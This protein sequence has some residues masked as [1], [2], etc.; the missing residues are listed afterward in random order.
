MQV[1][2]DLP[3]S[4]AAQVSTESHHLGQLLARALRPKPPE[5]SALRREVLSFLAAGPR[6][7]EIIGFR[8][9]E[10]AAA[11]MRD[12]LSRSKTG[13][14]SPDEE[15]EMDDIEEVDQ[16]VALIKAEARKHLR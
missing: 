6:P 3:D 16:L 15:A 13:T 2:V 1:T 9:S 11:R 10:I 7:R 5:M 12:L 8:P 14:L 4:L